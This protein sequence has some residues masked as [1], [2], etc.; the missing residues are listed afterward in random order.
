MYFLGSFSIIFALLFVIAV[1][2]MSAVYLLRGTIGLVD[3]TC[4]TFARVFGFLK[5]LV[6]GQKDGACLSPSDSLKLMVFLLVVYIAVLV[7]VASVS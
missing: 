7:L 1:L 5:R 2:A 6:L 3:A 4:T